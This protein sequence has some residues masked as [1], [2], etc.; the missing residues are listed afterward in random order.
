M[1]ETPGYDRDNVFARI[2]RDEI[3]SDRVYEDGEFIA[4]RDINPA[5]PTHIVL[6]PR[7]EPPAGPAGLDDGDAGWAGRMFVVASRI[8]AQEGLAEGGYR[9]VVNNGPDAGQE[10]PHLHMHIL[11]GAGLGPIA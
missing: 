6:I 8:A 4:F 11:G 1:S 9:L 3:P 7:G 5:A 10:V 2:L